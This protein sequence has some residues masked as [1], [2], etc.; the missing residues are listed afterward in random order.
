MHVTTERLSW[1]ERIGYGSSDLA[2]NFVSQMIIT[3]LVVFYTDVFGLQPS[4][5]ATLFLVAGF[6]DAANSLVWGAIIDN[7]KSRWGKSR[8]Y[9]LW[10]CLP[11]A[12]LS[13]L[14]FTVPDLNKD[15]K[16]AYAYIT[17]I[18][19]LFVNSGIGNSVNTLLTSITSN[20]RERITLMSVRMVCGMAGMAIVTSITIPLVERLGNGNDG[21][22]YFRVA[23]IF[24]V[25]SVFFYLFSFSKIRERV[26]LDQTIK[27]PLKTGIKAFKG[28]HLWFLALCIVFF[29]W[30]GN[31]VSLATTVYYFRYN[32]QA[33]ELIPYLFLIKALAMMLIFALTPTIVSRLGKRYSI[34]TG[35]FLAVIGQL[36]F[37]AYGLHAGFAIAGLLLNS[38]GKGL[39][40]GMFTLFIADSVDYG[41]RRTGIKAQGLLTSLSGI[42][43]K[44]GSSLGSALGPWILAIGHYVPNQNIQPASALTSIETG[45]LWLPIITYILIFLAMLK[46]D[47]TTMG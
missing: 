37:L 5:V 32:M 34:M 1:K 39:I 17:Y 29:Y 42:G 36:L 23:V 21:Q 22:G 14:V 18:L 27:L 40:M 28:N 46:Y 43:V 24:A 44:I 12:V 4:V 33:S 7:T 9:L 20:P 47:T 2:T 16:I 38:F 26:T 15:G 11:A 25:I 13:V 31:S 30:L 3:Y 8:P 35:C 10:L 41:F 19:I 45:F 6:A